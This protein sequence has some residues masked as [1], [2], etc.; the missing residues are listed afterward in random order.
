MKDLFNQGPEPNY[1]VMTCKSRIS[2]KPTRVENDNDNKSMVAMGLHF[3][4]LLEIHLIGATRLHSIHN[5]PQSS[6]Y[7]IWCKHRVALNG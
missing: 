7:K 2:G 1:L 6:N 5:V 4:A 3:N